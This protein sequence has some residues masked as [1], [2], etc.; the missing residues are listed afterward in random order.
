MWKAMKSLF[1]ELLPGWVK[2][3]AVARQRARQ[4][5]AEAKTEGTRIGDRPIR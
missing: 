2:A 5:D 1:A 4:A 3:R